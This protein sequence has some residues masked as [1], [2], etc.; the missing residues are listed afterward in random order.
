MVTKRQLAALAYGRSV[1]Q[2]KLTKARYQKRARQ[3][4]RTRKG[5]NLSFD[6]IIKGVG[7][8]LKTFGKGAKAVA[9]GLSNFVPV[10]GNVVNALELG[11]RFKTAI[12][13]L[14]EDESTLDTNKM[15]MVMNNMKKRLLEADPAMKDEPIFVDFAELNKS[16]YFID[17]LQDSGEKEELQHEIHNALQLF[18]KIIAEYNQLMQ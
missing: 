16:L 15:K 6:S 10:L 2:A 17:M 8:G 14:F 4:K 1:R 12:K 11:G 13:S 3:C 5:T 7:T 18:K 9:T